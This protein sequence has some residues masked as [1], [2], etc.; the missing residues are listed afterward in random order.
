MRMNTEC[1]R[2]PETAGCLA[3]EHI[4]RGASS[5]VGCS[6]WPSI[7]VNCF[8]IAVVRQATPLPHHFPG[9]FSHHS[10]R[11]CQVLHNRPT[12]YSTASTDWAGAFCTLRSWECT[13]IFRG[14]S[15]GA[16]A[17]QRDTSERASAHISLA[18]RWF[19]W[20]AEFKYWCTVNSCRFFSFFV[21]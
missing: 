4:W 15:N 20:M 3:W 14:K 6:R 21:R 10:H 12:S 16:K 9:F 13:S 19:V 5:N 8:Y 2:W 11:V 1:K 7:S 18:S 17:N